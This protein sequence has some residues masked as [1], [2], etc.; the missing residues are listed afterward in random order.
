MCGT[1]TYNYQ[2]AE[3][4]YFDYSNLQTTDCTEDVSEGS[5]RM[6]ELLNKD[7]E[8]NQA[9]QFS[10]FGKRWIAVFHSNGNYQDYLAIAS[11]AA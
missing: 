1:Q 8:K 4:T 11:S 6:A 10:A 7:I 9:L 3:N 5:V 2:V